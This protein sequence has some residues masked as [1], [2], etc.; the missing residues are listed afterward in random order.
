MDFVHLVTSSFALLY[1]FLY[2][3]NHPHLVLV[4]CCHLLSSLRYVNTISEDFKDI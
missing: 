3:Y 2:F 1:N 4:L